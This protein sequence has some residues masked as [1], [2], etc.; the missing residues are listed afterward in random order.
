MVDRRLYGI[1]ALFDNPEKVLSAAKAVTNAGY[2]EFDAYTP[3]PLHG[4]DN[5]MK[6]KRSMI[7]KV[8]L[9]AG[10]TGVVSL[11]LFT[12]WAN[13]VDYPLWIGGKPFFAWPSYVPLMFEM[14]VLFGAVTTVISLL[15]IWLGL[16]RNSHPLHDTEFMRRISD[17][18]FGICVEASDPIFE[19]KQTAEFL[20]GLGGEN[21][22]LAYHEAHEISF[23]SAVLD[24]RF[25]VAAIIVAVISSGLV[26][27]GLNKLL[28]LR[29]WSSLNDQEK[30]L[31][32]TRSAFYPDGFAM[33]PPVEGTVSRS[34]MPFEFENDLTSAEKGLKNP[35]LPS[36]RVMELGQ[37]DFNIYC[38]PCHGYFAD[39]DSRLQGQFPN[40]PSLH[41]DSLRLAPDGLYYYVITSGF[42]NV[43]P[44]YSRQILP[45]ER[46]AIIW[47]I[48]ALQKS[49]QAEVPVTK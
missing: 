14:G 30:V 27:L 5:A 13:S 4:L 25:I 29:P 20:R 33:R 7:G 43:M 44:S 10:M 16:P 41:T 26:Y 12:W 1:T 42:Q 36:K 3:Y 32:E 45:D 38:S 11:I 35:L 28:L 24:P 49:Q 47:Y 6:L 23:R 2:K 39:G 31:P 37:R 18:R 34:Q 15:A 21:V 8:T 40:P 22:E 46:W 19:Q 9:T 48:R 17:D